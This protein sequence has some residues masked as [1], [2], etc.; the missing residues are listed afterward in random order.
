MEGSNWDM[1]QVNIALKLF[2]ACNNTIYINK[3]KVFLHF[4]I[5]SVI[6]KTFMVINSWQYVRK[7]EKLKLSKTTIMFGNAVFWYVLII[8]QI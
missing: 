4:P 5:L 8:L 2:G 7:S 6:S 3:T 1:F